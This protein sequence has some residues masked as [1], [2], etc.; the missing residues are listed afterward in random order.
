MFTPE[1]LSVMQAAINTYSE[2]ARMILNYDLQAALASS[3]LAKIE[4]YNPLTYFSKQEL[5]FV[6]MSVDYVISTMDSMPPA[7]RDK[8]LYK[9]LVALL[10]RL[11]A[12]AR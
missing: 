9:S 8:K 7:R 12:L 1:E 2:E 6:A 11:I 4:H 10:D 5:T 3:C